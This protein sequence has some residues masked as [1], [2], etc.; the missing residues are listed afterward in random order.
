MSTAELV[1]TV[2]MISR[3][4]ASIVE[5][6]S[7]TSMMQSLFSGGLASVAPKDKKI[8]ALE[9]SPFR[10]QGVTICG[11]CSPNR[12][13]YAGLDFM[14]SDAMFRY[15]VEIRKLL[16][17]FQMPSIMSERELLLRDLGTATTS[18]MRPYSKFWRT[19]TSACV[20][21]IQSCPVI[22]TS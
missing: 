20:S 16:P 6:V 12:F 11:S 9:L 1:N 22:P 15:S 2:S 10:H 7:V 21:L 3:L 19:S 17:L 14:Y 13:T 8:F 18:C 4:F 5:P